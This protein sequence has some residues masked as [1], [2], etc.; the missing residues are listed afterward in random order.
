VFNLYR[1]P[2]P[3]KPESPPVQVRCQESE[4]AYPIGIK[5]WL[6]SYFRNARSLPPR[7]FI[8]VT[9]S[10]TPEMARYILEH[11]NSG[12]RPI[13][14]TRVQHFVRYISE[15]RWRTIAQGISFARNEVLNNGQHRLAAIVL[16]GKSVEI[17][18]VF[19]EDRKDFDVI[20]AGSVRTGAHVLTI[21]GHKHAALLAACAKLLT[22]IIENRVYAPR[23]I[24]ND[25]VRC[26]VADHPRLEDV[27][28]DAARVASKLKCSPT[29]LAV[30]FYLIMTKSQR[31]N[32]LPAFVS[33]LETGAG[34]EESSP[35]L[36]LR[37]ALQTKSV[38]ANV[39]SGSA[40]TMAQCAG[41]IQAWKWFVRGHKGSLKGIQWQPRQT[42]PTVE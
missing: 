21:D 38:D 31:C 11:H 29:A 34:L 15:G 12:N 42:F 3:L 8:G 16:A 30:A 41:A 22:S 27:C 2:T 39:R 13:T 20:D 5:E 18:F 36:K 9:V 28:S 37:D 32:R 23:R 25:E 35:I 4:T 7:Q 40:R 33:G 14:D 24:D 19:G 10:V 6:D 26:F 1:Q 17:Y